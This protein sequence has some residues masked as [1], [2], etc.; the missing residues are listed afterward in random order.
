MN[1][2][3]TYFPYIA[4]ATAAIIWGAN[5]PIMK[6]TMLYV[7][8]FSLAFLRFFIASLILLPFV[9]KN[10]T[11]K[12]SDWF[13]LFLCAFLGITILITLY[14]LGLRMTSALN[15]GI[16]GG[17]TPI[18]TLIF[19]ALFLHEKLTKKIMLGAVIGLIGILIIVGKD[20]FV[21]GIDISPIGDML[22][23]LSNIVFAAYITLSKKLSKTYSPLTLTFFIFFIGSLFFLPGVFIDATSNPTWIF[24]LPPFAYF[25]IL[26]GILLSGLLAFG[27]WQFGISK[28][29]ETNVGFF[30]YISP[31]VTTL[32]A[33][34]FLGEHVTAE[35]LI[36]SLLIVIGLLVAEAHLHHKRPHH[37]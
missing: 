2:F 15:T 12:K 17:T 34:T 9:Y 33:I 35:F 29:S 21:Q 27:L 20:M 32:I 28:V 1:S 6:V 37:H 23:F 22:I 30:L 25:G 26:Y 3:K 5:T 14:F 13:P 19:A 31:I 18:I 7:P 11:F 16:I 8:I 4:L 10:L 36:G 24:N